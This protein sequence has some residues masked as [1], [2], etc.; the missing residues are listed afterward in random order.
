MNTQE[1]IARWQS[2]APQ[3]EARG[4]HF[5]DVRSYLTPEMKRNYQIAMDAQPAL[6][7]TVNSGIPALF[8]TLV[9]PQV[10]EIL[11]A[12]TRAAEILGE[13]KRGS[14]TDQTQLFP[15][16]EHSGE[17]A[18]YN[19][20]SES[21]GNQVNANWPARQQYLFQT[22]KIL[23]DL[24]ID[25]AGAGHLNWVAETDKATANTM[26]RALNTLFFFGVS[27]M[28][29]YGLLNDPN[30][31]AALTPSTKAAGGTK[32]INS[33]GQII[34]TANEI[35]GDVQ[36]LFISLSTASGGLIDART[37]MVLSM[38]PQSELA[39]TTTNSFAVNVYDLLKKN[40]PNIRFESAVQYGVS[41]TANPQGVT[42]GNLLQMIAENVE[43]QKTG[44]CAYSEKMRAHPIVRMTSSYR[45][46]N[47][48]GSWGAVIRQPFAVSSMVGV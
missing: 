9:D 39:M 21:G 8:T 19:D 29:N 22:M 34:A 48:G 12:P 36:S 41:S 30:L 24:E 26:N 45:Q 7:T 35:F 2:D 16:V 3:F 27:G 6:T 10:F 42:A 31:N 11:F 28:Q 15:T 18:S 37:P 5:P 38:S 32:W 44:Y 1:A 40:F 25:R 13:M 46:K 4:V 43:G 20:F 17:V 33:S 14:W 23:G 47:T